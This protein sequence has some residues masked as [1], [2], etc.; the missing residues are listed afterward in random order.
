MIS[1][2]DTFDTQLSYRFSND[3]R[4]MKGLTLTIGANNVFDKLAPYAAGAFNDSYDTRTA[5]NYG[6]QVYANIRKEF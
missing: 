4:Y 5:N 2:F 3:N 1:A 6:R